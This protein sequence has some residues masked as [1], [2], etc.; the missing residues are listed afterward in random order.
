[1]GLINA[2][3]L[4]LLEINDVFR[5]KLATMR[6]SKYTNL[7]KTFSKN[8]I[9]HECKIFKDEL[10]AYHE[11]QEVFYWYVHFEL[12]EFELLCFNIF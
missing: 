9:S 7:V 11:D 10:L 1:M 3:N 5:R 4:S 8:E 12:Y 6:T 2:Q